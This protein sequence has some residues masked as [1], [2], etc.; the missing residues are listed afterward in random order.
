M[1]TSPATGD[2]V[3]SPRVGGIVTGVAGRIEWVHEPTR[4]AELAQE[5]DRL[6][7]AQPSPF[8]DHAWFQ[9]WWGAF[10]T[11]RLAVCLLWEN[12]QLQAAL[13]L[14]AHRGRLSGLANYHTPLFT[15]P[16][17]D[18]G[19][20]RRL[21]EEALSRRDGELALQAVDTADPFYDAVVA[22][23]RQEGRLL[24]VEK[25]HRSPRVDMEGDFERFIRGRGRRFRDI[26]R[27][28]RKLNREH[29]V[30]FRFA[31]PFQSLETELERGFQIEATGWKGERGTAILSAASTR[32]F[33]TAVARAYHSRGELRLIWLDIDGQ[34]AAFNYC[35]AR[36]R[37][38][39]CLKIGIDDR[40]RPHAP[41]L[42]ID[43]CTVQRCFELGLDRYELLGADE[44]YKRYFAT[45]YA[46]HVRLRSYRRQPAPVMRYLTRRLAR[47][48]VL[49]ARERLAR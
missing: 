5:W 6:T 39:Y 33:Y 25:T 34:A 36:S 27:R 9:A 43:Y 32:A 10:G 4:F 1:S 28:W 11:G 26:P 16:A 45:A 40:F 41:G 48:V 29:Q 47:P 31:E 30:Q 46:D 35:L 23:A 15:A 19:A 24:L 22:A 38:L 13:P 17:S 37:R 7:G 2:I 49:A 18:G 12:E 3:P 20:R 21:V 44:P 42:L 14:H 8:A